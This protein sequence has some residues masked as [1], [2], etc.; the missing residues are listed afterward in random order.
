MNDRD[1]FEQNGY[2]IFDTE[3]DESLFNN[4]IRT[5]QHDDNNNRVQD[6]WK[7]NTFVKQLSLNVKILKKLEELYKKKPLPFQVLNFN[8]GT[9]QKIHSDTIHFNSYPSGNMCGVWVALEDV[10]ENNGPLFYYP[11]SHKEPELNM[12][13]FKLD[14]RVQDYPEYELMLQKLIETKNY[15]KRYATLKKGQ[16]IIWAANLLHGG[17]DIR[18]KESSRYSQATHYF[19]NSEYY[20]TPLLSSE[21]NIC[22]RNPIWIV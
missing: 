8:K 1:F 15:I 7:T 20:Y 11:G 3:I 2:L 18:N 22:Y 16:A 17:S 19:F 14:N 21:N 9:Q 5:V 10:T 6:A 13:S 4:I 12:Q